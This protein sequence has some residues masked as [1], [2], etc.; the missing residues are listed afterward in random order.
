MK[1]NNYKNLFELDKGVTYLNCANMSPLL[2]SVKEAG[3]NA[4]ERRGKPWDLVSLD[5][6]TDG[7]VLRKKAANI[8]RTTADNISFIPSASYGLAT[9]AKNFHL[10]NSKSIILIEDQFPS[11]YYVW[12]NLS[13]KLDLKIITIKKENDKLLTESILENINSETA[14][15]AIPNC[16]WIDGSLIDLEKISKA[17]KEVNAH[18]VLDLSQSLGVLPINIDKID[19]DFAVSV[20]YKWMLGPYSFGYMYVSPRWQDKGE[21]LEY[22]WSTRK[23]SEDFSTLTNY[24]SEYRTGARKFDMGEFSQ[25]NT[26]RMAI[27]ALDQ[28][29]NWGVENIQSYTKILT[30]YISENLGKNIN[31]QKPVTP[32][33]G[34]IIAVPIGNNAKGLKNKLSKNKIVVSYRGSFIRISPHLYNDISEIDKFINCLK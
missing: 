33:A 22:N 2:K 30:N 1:T 5:W 25:F 8:F 9:A 24:T 4:L 6:F 10:K 11:N 34:H 13:K 21:P 17:I 23:G 14:I 12:D 26:L 31:Y 19:P 7:E 28:I 20:G 18:L 27:A 16:H 3:I 29:L 32:N 15:V